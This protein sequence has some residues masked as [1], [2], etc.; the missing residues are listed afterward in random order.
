MKKNDDKTFKES[1]FAI[2]VLGQIF[3]LGGKG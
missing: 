3:R 1:P 2:F